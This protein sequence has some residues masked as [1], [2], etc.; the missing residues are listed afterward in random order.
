M[1]KVPDRWNSSDPYEFFM[2]R[3]SKLMAPVFLQWLNFPYYKSWLDL[4]CGTGA[5]S[6]AIA[7]ACKPESLFCVDP[8]QRSFQKQ[9]KEVYKTPNFLLETHPAFRLQIAVLILLFPD[10]HSTFS[11]N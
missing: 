2:G 7:N 5:L 10:L 4:G 6:E 8:S 11:L 3:W 1:E 9:R